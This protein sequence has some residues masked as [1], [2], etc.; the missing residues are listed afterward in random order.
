M[1]AQIDDEAKFTEMKGKVK[2]NDQVDYTTN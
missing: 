1:Y 2:I